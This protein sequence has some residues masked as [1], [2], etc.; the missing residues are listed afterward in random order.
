MTTAR[1]KVIIKSPKR[2]ILINKGNQELQQNIFDTFKYPR[3]RQE[4]ESYSRL[5]CRYDWENIDPTYLQN[6]AAIED[7]LLF[8]LLRT[9]EVV[10][11]ENGRNTPCRKYQKQTIGIILHH[12]R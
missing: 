6:Y 5:V 7:E 3:P 12:A 9:W 10:K 11:L 8:A 4:C 1:P 2:F